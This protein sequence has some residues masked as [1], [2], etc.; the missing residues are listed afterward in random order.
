VHDDQAENSPERE[1][2]SGVLMYV[3]FILFDK[4]VS[5][6]T[7]S[8]IFYFR[9]NV[10]ERRTDGKEKRKKEMRLNK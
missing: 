4:R 1:I 9:I 2:K 6:S 5:S 8:F 3:C 7:H 10:Q